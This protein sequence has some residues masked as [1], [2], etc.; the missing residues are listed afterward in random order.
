M[1]AIGLLLFGVIVVLAG[2]LLL[3]GFG[4]RKVFTRD[5]IVQALI[6]LGELANAEGHALT[7]VV[8]GGAALVLRYNARAST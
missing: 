5:E 7:L 8:V 2:R 1:I 3:A 4:S 6:R